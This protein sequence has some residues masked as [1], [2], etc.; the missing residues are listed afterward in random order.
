MPASDLRLFLPSKDGGAD[1]FTP[2]TRVAD[3]GSSALQIIDAGTTQADN[4]WNDA[5]VR[6]LDTTTTV[7]LRGKYARV[8]TWTQGPA[9][10]DLF[11]ALPDVPVAGDEFQ[12]WTGGN[13]RSDFAAEELDATGIVNVTGVTID[14]ALYANLEGAGTLRYKNGTTA[15][16]WQAP[17]SA[18]EGAEVD[19]SIDGTYVIE[20]GE[21]VNKA[22]VVTV[23]AASLPGSDQNDT[24]TLAYI[25]E[26]L[27]VLTIEGSETE[28]GAV[29][30]FP[31]V[32]QNLAAGNLTDVRAWMEEDADP[33]TTS[34]AFGQ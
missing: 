3:V 1:G 23:V 29:R 30:Y 2:P 24:I 32:A 10:L 12:M 19:V 25:K 14:R 18:T 13:Y 4:F 31:I 6:F 20:D 28:S 9:T 33:G 16:T 27:G 22:L 5:L 11:R 7:A 8:E 15:L 26:A 21:D 17:G 34:I